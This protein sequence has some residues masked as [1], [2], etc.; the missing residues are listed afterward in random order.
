MWP[1]TRTYSFTYIRT[2]PYTDAYAC[3]GTY[4]YTYTYAYTS[5]HT[6]TCTMQIPSQH[7]HISYLYTY[8]HTQIYIYLDIYIYMYP[9]IHVDGNIHVYVHKEPVREETHF[10]RQ[11]NTYIIRWFPHVFVRIDDP[12]HPFINTGKASTH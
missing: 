6:Y 12:L 8:I 3:R 1:C 5:T 10:K 7:T 11:Y 9:C 2:Y 4:T